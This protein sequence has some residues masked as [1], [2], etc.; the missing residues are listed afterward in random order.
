MLSAC[1]TVPVEES[2]GKVL[3][4]PSVGCPPAVPI[5]ICGEQIDE[6]AAAAMTY[7]GMES[8]TVVYFR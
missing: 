2:I 3:S 5:V 4:A 6:V 7:Y 8:C 1:E